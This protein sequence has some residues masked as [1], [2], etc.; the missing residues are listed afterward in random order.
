MSDMEI[1]QVKVWIP[2]E[3]WRMA[4]VEAAKRDTSMSR[5]V[6]TAV[7]EKTA[8]DAAAERDA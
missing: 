6:A 1:V 4:K 8:R 7:R 2:V 5:F 3:V